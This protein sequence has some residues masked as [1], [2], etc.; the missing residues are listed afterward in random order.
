MLENKLDPSRR[1]VLAGIGGMAVAGLTG[2]ATT[3]SR[4]GTFFERTGVPIGLQ[5]YTLG[6]EAGEDL[7]AT[8]AEVA[9]IGYRDIEMPGLMGHSAAAI[10]SAAQRT[11]L[12]ISSVHVPLVDMQRGGGLTFAEEPAAI[13]DTL[14]EL[15]AAWAVA[16][17]GLIP[18]DFR[19]AP[20]EDIGTALS[21][22]VAAGG[23]DLWHRTAE[24]L[25]RQGAALKALGIRTGYHNHNLEFAPIGDTNGWE[26]LKSETDHDL[27]SFEIDLGWIA[28]A[29]FDPVEF[30]ADNSGRVALV[31]VKDVAEGNTHGYA[32]SM[33]PAE[34]GSGTLSWNRLLPAAHAAGARH[35]YVEQEPPFSI[36]R[37]EAARKSFDFLSKSG[38]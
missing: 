34:V 31:H 18:S 10:R 28:T 8:F 30:L 4:G 19:P 36:P 26:I 20:G 13:A 32:L 33:K 27:I 29:G 37:I 3:T 22:A 5:I 25:N 35:F 15:G 16:P 7:D 9:K 1:T 38:I 23:A 24:I 11:G 6:P 12:S 2:C 21:R 14:G 17:M